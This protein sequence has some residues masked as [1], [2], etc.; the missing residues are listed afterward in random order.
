M[1]VNITGRNVDL[2]ND[3]KRYMYKRLE[4]FDRIYSRISWAEVIVYEEKGMT[5]VEVIIQLKRNRIIAKETSP[6]L[7]ATVD[8]A[9]DNIKNQLKRLN[10]R[11]RS[12]R[13]LSVMKR[14]MWPFYRDD[15]EPRQGN[16]Y[17]EN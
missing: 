9:A 16:G 5:T 6:D 8:A 7:Y 13:R 10:G 11:V 3:E 1:D 17:D 4:K 2:S 14:L 15:K 12:R